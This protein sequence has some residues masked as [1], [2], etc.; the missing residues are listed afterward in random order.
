MLRA[1]VISLLSLAVISSAAAQKAAKP[2]RSAQGPMDETPAQIRAAL[3]QLEKEWAAA[4][5]KRDVKKL[6][7]II[8]DEW[9]QISPEGKVQTK[10]D[11]LDTLKAAGP[12][13]GEAPELSDI[14]VLTFGNSAQ[15]WGRVKEAS[16]VPGQERSGHYIFGDLFVRRKG[17]WQAIYSHTTKVSE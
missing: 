9:V 15:V 11:L 8:A 7:E 10:K 13:A 14:K 1:V 2:A 6:D 16:A 17:G 3:T 12:Q 5:A 4:I